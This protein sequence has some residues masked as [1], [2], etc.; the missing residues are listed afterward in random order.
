MP[1]IDTPVTLEFVTRRAAEFAPVRIR[2]MAALTKG[3]EGHER[4][5]IGFLSVHS[6]QL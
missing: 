3:R 2:H 1:A 5:E 6:R 4:T